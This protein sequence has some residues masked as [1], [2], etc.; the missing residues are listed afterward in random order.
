MRVPVSSIGLSELIYPLINPSACIPTGIPCLLDE[1]CTN[2]ACLTV[3]SRTTPT[4]APSDPTPAT[5]ASTR[6]C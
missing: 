6:Q 2:D 4:S 1:S 3:T 5:S